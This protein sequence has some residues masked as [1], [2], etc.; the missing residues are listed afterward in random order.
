MEARVTMTLRFPPDEAE[1][2]KAEAER[3]AKDVTTT[4]RELVR[5]ALDAREKRRA[6]DATK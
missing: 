5:E 1:R 4:T 2:L 6:K 3:V